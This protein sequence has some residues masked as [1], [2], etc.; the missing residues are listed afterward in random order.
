MEPSTR[1]GEI[2]GQ[3]QKKKRKGQINYNEPELIIVILDPKN[4]TLEILKNTS[5]EDINSLL[6]PDSEILKNEEPLNKKNNVRSV[7]ELKFKPPPMGVLERILKKNNDQKLN[8][9]INF[10]PPPPIPQTFN[11]TIPPTQPTTEIIP[12]LPEQIDNIPVLIPSQLTTNLS[13]QFQDLYHQITRLQPI[14]NYFDRFASDG[15]I[16]ILINNFKANYQQILSISNIKDF[17]KIFFNMLQELNSI[18]NIL[19]PSNE[20]SQEE[21]RIDYNLQP[22]ISLLETMGDNIKIIETIINGVI[23]KFNLALN[24]VDRTSGSDFDYNDLFYLY[25]GFNL[26]QFPLIKSFLDYQLQSFPPDIQLRLQNVQQN[27][28]EQKFNDPQAEYKLVN[29]LL[30][31]YGL[32]FPAVLNNDLMTRI[33]YNLKQYLPMLLNYIQRNQNDSSTILKAQQYFN[34]DINNPE[35]IKRIYE[36]DLISYFEPT[37]IGSTLRGIQTAQ[38]GIQHA[39]AAVIDPFKRTVSYGLTWAKNNPVAA[40]GGL[41]SSLG[42]GTLGINAIN[43]GNSLASQFTKDLGRYTLQEGLTDSITRPILN[44]VPNSFQGMF[45]FPVKF[46]VS[47]G[48]GS[49]LDVGELAA[50]AANSGYNYFADGLG[51]IRDL[52][53]K[54]VYTIPSTATVNNPENFQTPPESPQPQTTERTSQQQRPENSQGWLDPISGYLTIPMGVAMTALG[55]TLLNARNPIN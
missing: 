44:Y 51:N 7:N 32:N 29:F 3:Y 1:S 54:V 9:N 48:V 45:K 31:K 2:I 34:L 13:S 33:Q 26:N 15:Y 25:N 8:Q 40:I 11:A 20:Q 47:S 4:R 53:G 49:L 55:G 35:Q 39:G 36:G 10:V 17:K 16:K 43:S 50:Q 46:F 5:F 41:T 38:R 24:V 19:K 23:Q 42:L 14:M 12:Q 22:E 28:S 52:T 37:T 21:I 27:R 18:L 6:P 30:Q